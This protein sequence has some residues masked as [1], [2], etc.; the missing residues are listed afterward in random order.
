MWLTQFA[1]TLPNCAVCDVTKQHLDLY[2]G[3]FEELSAKSRNDRRAIVKQFLRLATAK[4]YL[5][6]QHRLFE[7]V[8]FKAEE[9]DPREIDFYRPKELRDM[10]NAA[11]AELLPVVALGGLG[12]VRREE[13]MRLDWEDV[14]RVPGHVEVGSRV[15]KGRK[16]RLVAVC[17]ALAAWLRPYR[18][19]T[20]RVWGKSPD[21]LEEALAGLRD[22][23]GV[24]AR[25]NGLRH[26]FVTF[27]MAAHVNENLTA[28][29]A[30]NSPQMI[31]DRYRGL[32]TRKEAAQWFSVK[33]ARG[34]RAEN[35][36]SMPAQARKGR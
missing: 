30:G 26:A 36:L 24:P 4:D 2:I 7:A 1:G 35:V 6:Q 22:S 11:D 16:R 29:E 25:R 17:P 18:N 5:P 12:G 15:A 21:A 27:H 19:A 10:L 31:H 14:F 3:R 13:I 8:G 33:P 23:L 9:Q 34:A 20:G 28:A 32:A